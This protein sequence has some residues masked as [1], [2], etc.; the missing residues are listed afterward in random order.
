MAEWDEHGRLIEGSDGAAP[1][2]WDEHG[3]PVAPSH[4]PP[5]RAG[6]IE[7]VARS[8][9]T[10]VQRGV[11]GTVGLTGDIGDMLTGIED[12]AMQMGR[13][14]F[15]PDMSDEEFEAHRQRVRSD[16]AYGLMRRFGPGGNPIFGRDPSSE[17]LNRAIEQAQ[18][19]PQYEPQTTAGEYAR[20]IGEM[21]PNALFPGGWGARAARVVVPGAASEAA[22][23]AT[24]GTPIEPLARVAGAVGGGLAT[25]ASLLSRATQAARQAPRAANEALEQEF[26]PMTR[27]ERSGNT[28]QRLD[29]E[30][31]RRGQGS[32]QAQSVMRGFDADRARQVRDRGM[33]IVSRG[34]EPISQNMDEAGVILGD[35]LRTARQNLHERAQ[36]QYDE[37]FRLARDERIP[38]SDEL[39]VR[40]DDVAREHMFDVPPGAARAL[41]TLQDEIQQGTAT[42]ARVERTRQELSRRR[43]EAAAQRQDGDEFVYATLIRELDDWN[44]GVIQSPQA[45]RAMDEARGIYREMRDLFGQRSRTQL[46]TGQTG[47]MDPGGRAVDR[48]INT[49]LTGEQIIDS[50][51]GAGTRPSQQALGAVRRIRELGTESIKYTNRAADSGVRLPGRRRVGGRTAAQRRFNADDPNAPGGVELPTDQLQALREGLMHRMFRPIDDYISRIETTGEGGILPAQ[52]MVTQL[53]NALNKSGRQIMETLY[54]KREME[55]MRRLLRYFQTIV[56]P[57]GVNYSGTTAG[58]YRMISGAL[59]KAVGVIPGL[60]PMLTEAASQA[61]STGAARAAIKPSRPRTIRV[62]PLDTPNRAVPVSSGLLALPE[63]EERFGAIGLG[64]R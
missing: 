56:P 38:P 6:V 9:A 7:D 8:A 3:R 25:E 40:I 45:R 14:L 62:S 34:Q 15:R 33:R 59:S 54:T 24:E 1:Q 39:G 37:A 61:A 13:R 2:E 51:I 63:D 20:T 10:G 41:R 5:R 28:R 44:A 27:G 57:A 50:I 23:Q 4:P 35:E 22:G 55:A 48:A 43:G 31:W 26:A 12:W 29:E 46:S 53:D 52:R 17:D 30:G 42:Q 21:A 36:A 18:G 19:R 64:P 60:G 47:R 49:E 16:P 58:I 32:D 11:T